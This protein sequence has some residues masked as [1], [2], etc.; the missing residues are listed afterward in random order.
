ME[1]QH[2]VAK[3][4]CEEFGGAYCSFYCFFSGRRSGDKELKR[5]WRNSCTSNEGYSEN[6]LTAFTPNAAK[7]YM[8]CRDENVLANVTEDV[9]FWTS[10]FSV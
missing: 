6:V 3:K 2:D 10:G 4:T 5:L 8:H 7:D 9:L 1:E